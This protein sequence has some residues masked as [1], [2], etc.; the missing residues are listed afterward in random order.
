MYLGRLVAGYPQSTFFK[1][2][3]ADLKVLGPA[4]ESPKE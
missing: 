4:T 1:D 3:E 2:A